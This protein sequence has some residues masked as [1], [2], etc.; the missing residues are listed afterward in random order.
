[1]R[2]YPPRATQ[3]FFAALAFG[4]LVHVAQPAQAQTTSSRPTNE[5]EG[6]VV[7]HTG[8]P[9]AGARVVVAFA[10]DGYINYSSPDSIFAYASTR[11]VL[12]FFKRRNGL[13][14]GEATT[15]EQ[16]RFVIK[17]LRPGMFNVIA[18]HTSRGSGVFRDVKQPNKGNPAELK[19]APPTFVEGSI[20]GF[21]QRGPKLFDGLDFELPMY[22]N[23]EIVGN[24]P[25]V[26]N[27]DD[28]SQIHVDPWVDL[29]EQGKFRVGPLPAGGAYTLLFDE[30][31]KKRS[32]VAP[33]LGAPVH[34]TPG[35][36][37]T[38]NIDRSKGTSLTGTVLGPDGKPLPWTSVSV[39]KEVDGGGS[40]IY[41]AITNEK[42][43]YA[44]GV[45]LTASTNCAA[46]A[47]PYARP[48]AEAQA[49]KMS[50][51]TGRSGCRSAT[52]NRRWS[53]LI[54]FSFCA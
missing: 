39:V 14:S 50:P 19:L 27:E 46:S 37:T 30:Y 29:D 52:R 4:V 26:K 3:A 31:V 16:G 6:R 47:T 32:Y 41:G 18:A 11:R 20:V 51:L 15:D 9:V 35:K 34:V 12:L 24:Y 2:L 21:E 42:G 7:D 22:G 44:I 48:L 43:E 23:L 33:M 17:G 53:R 1:M 40:Y 45:S 25:W 54:A 5:F 49:P 10:E 36:T 13:G 28:R 38:V 8:Q